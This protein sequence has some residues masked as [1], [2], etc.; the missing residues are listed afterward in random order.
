MFPQ[1]VL[2]NTAQDLYVISYSCTPY[3][4]IGFYTICRTFLSFRGLFI[5]CILKSISSKETSQCDIAS[6][7]IQRLM[8]VYL[9]LIKNL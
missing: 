2:T 7:R 4:N 8:D 6:R 1:D 9:E 5:G 3:L